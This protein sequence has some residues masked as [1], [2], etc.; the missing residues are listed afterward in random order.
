MTTGLVFVKFELGTL[1]DGGG[2]TDVLLGIIGILNFLGWI[3]SF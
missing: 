2:I 3:Q 1:I